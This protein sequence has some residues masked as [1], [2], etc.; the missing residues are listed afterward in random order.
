M[1]SIH[2]GFLIFMLIL[3]LTLMITVLYIDY[4]N[5]SLECRDPTVLSASRIVFMLGSL[6]F[7]STATL[8]YVI[9]LTDCGYSEGQWNL[10]YTI[11]VIIIGLLLIVTGGIISIKGKQVNCPVAVRWSPII[12]GIVMIMIIFTIST[13]I[14]GKVGKQENLASLRKTLNAEK[15]AAA[16]ESASADDRDERDRT[17]QEIKSVRDSKRDFKTRS[18]N[19]G[20]NKSDQVDD[21]SPSEQG[22]SAQAV[23]RFASSLNVGG[24]SASPGVSKTASEGGYG[25][26]SGDNP[27]SFKAV[28]KKS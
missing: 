22:R 7:G 17:L 26:L 5:T 11:F 6:L 19:K 4:A 24:R 1:I 10:A 12:W 28:S 16:Y 25:D 20:G 18:R 15:R 27:F 14:W 2:P 8:L 21:R 3:G 9:L 13:F 23:D